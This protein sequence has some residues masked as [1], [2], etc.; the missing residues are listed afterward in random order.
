MRAHIRN[1]YR[2]QIKMILRS[3]RLWYPHRGSNQSRRTRLRLRPDIGCRLQ[4]RLSVIA[5]STFLGITF[6]QIL[7][8]AD[9]DWPWHTAVSWH[10]HTRTRVNTYTSR[11]TEWT[12]LQSPR[13]KAYHVNLQK[14]TLCER[15]RGIKRPRSQRTKMVLIVHQTNFWMNLL[16]KSHTENCHITRIGLSL[17]LFFL[18]YP[19]VC[20]RAQLIFRSGKKKRFSNRVSFSSIPS[21]VS[22][23]IGT[24]DRNACRF[25]PV[26]A[27]AKWLFSGQC[28]P[29]KNPIPAKEQGIIQTRESRMSFFPEFKH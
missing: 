13:A 14:L 10:A 26:R 20:A 1:R 28:S 25:A 6:F 8:L 24:G 21:V 11:P 17:S 27:R 15:A 18:L 3:P 9:I 2:S 16:L 4:I 12:T 19:F 23:P 7:L 22:R 5:F 29:I